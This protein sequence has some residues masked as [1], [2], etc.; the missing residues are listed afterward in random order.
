MNATMS[1]QDIAEF[2]KAV[3]KFLEGAATLSRLPAEYNASAELAT[4]LAGCLK[5]V[6]DVNKILYAE[7]DANDEDALLALLDLEAAL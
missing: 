4:A 7:Y 2:E 3:T 1:W 5:I 6:D